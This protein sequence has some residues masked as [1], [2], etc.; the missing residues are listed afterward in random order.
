MPNA[1]YVGTTGGLRTEEEDHPP[2]GDLLHVERWAPGRDLA[3][4]IVEG[5]AVWNTEVDVTGSS[6]TTS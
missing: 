4:R 3:L 1:W 6:N 2:V 5:L